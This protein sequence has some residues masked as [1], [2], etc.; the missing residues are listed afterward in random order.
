MAKGK[1]EHRMLF[2]LRG[3][4]RGQ[5][6][7][8]V[9]ALLAVLMGLS[10]FLVIG[11]FNLAELFNSN[12]STGDPAKPYEEQAERL[13]AKLKKDPGDPDLLVGL[14]RAHVNAGNALVAINPET[15]QPGATPESRQQYQEAADTWSTYLDAT[16]NPSPSLARVVAPAFVALTIASGTVP[17]ATRNI[18]GAID[19]QEI[20]ASKNPS[21]G[22]VANLA[23][24]QLFA[25]D[26]AGAEESE[27]KALALA[28]SAEERKTIKK[29][30]AEYRKNAKGT[31]VT[32]EKA[33]KEEGEAAKAGG[34][35]L[36]QSLG[37]G[38]LLGE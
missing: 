7:K 13:E 21:V 27:K 33:E 3:G 1:D 22:S 23:I 2:D 26:Y 25:F 14:T 19:A 32:F 10:L 36:G 15:G 4:R 37:G 6:V 28:T 34:A 38:G 16:E 24:Y 18:E 9:Y 20:A 31:Q 30:L 12:T 29:Q 5:V 17:E 35:G 11:G 8:V